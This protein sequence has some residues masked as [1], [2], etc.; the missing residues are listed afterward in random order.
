MTYQQEA[1]QMHSQG[2]NR[3]M[4]G[5]QP[6]SQQ[7]TSQMGMTR[8]EGLS[9]TH[10][11]ALTSISEAIQVCAWC[12][13]QCIGMG[14]PSMVQC[15]QYC[16]DVQELGEA[17]FVLLAR[18]SQ[19]SIPAVTTLQQAMGACAQEC[20]QHDDA[21]CQDCAQT[22]GRATETLSQLTGGR[23]TMQSGQ[24]GGTGTGGPA[25]SGGQGQFAPR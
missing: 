6:G 2:G 17:A 7:M 23:R 9:Q 14:D 13:D 12:A 15:I 20:A 1:T 8:H 25:M 5:Q 3:Q 19:H 4:G 18:N 24:Q 11:Q 22:L 21:H 10:R 16:E